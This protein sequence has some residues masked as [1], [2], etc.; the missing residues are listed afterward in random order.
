MTMI[1]HITTREAW[2]QAE[3]AGAY[4][5]DTLDTQGF[6]HCSTAFQVVRV[7]NTFY[8]GQSGLVLLGIETDKVQ[9]R[10]VFEQPINPATGEVEPGSEQFPHIYGALN[11]D[12][13]VQ[14]IDFPPNANG[15]FTLT[16]GIGD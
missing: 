5:G 10:V 1:Y 11:L 12:A 9:P 15:S 16:D 6:I 14:V 7:A 13:V 4:R 8:R 2:E 3:A